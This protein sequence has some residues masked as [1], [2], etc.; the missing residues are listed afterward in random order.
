MRIVLG[1]LLAAAASA[2]GMFLLRDS[3]ALAVAIGVIAFVT[4]L[5][6]FERR[7][8]PDDARALGDFLRRRST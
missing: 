4:V 7:V 6:A 2:V 8:Y 3:F 1:P 5:V